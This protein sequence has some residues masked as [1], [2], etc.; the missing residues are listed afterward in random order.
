MSHQEI[1]RVGIVE[2]I[3]SKKLSQIEGSKQLN[4]SSRQMRRLQKRYRKE[5][6]EGLLSKHRGKPSNNQLSEVIKS[7]VSKLIRE[8]YSDFGPTLAH[9]KLV[10]QH[11]IKLS[12]ERV[13]QLMIADELW[14]P[15]QRKTKRVFQLRPRRERFGE[16]IQIDGSP[17][18]W[19]E[20]RSDSCTLI[21]FID[22]A[23]R[24]L[25]SLL[26]S[27]TETTK[28]YMDVLKNHMAHYGRPVSLYSDRHGIFRVNQ[29]EAKS[30]NGHTQF[31]R[32]LDTLDVESIQA[33]TPQAKGRV[34]RAN[35][36]LQDR[37]VKEMRLKGINNLD[38]ANTF[39]PGFISDFNQRFKKPA[40][41]KEDAHR[42][43]L[44]T[45]REI[46]LILSRHSKRKVSNQLEISYEKTI[47]Q[48]QGKRH[49]LKQK[50]ITVCDLFSKE[51]VLLYEGKE[52]AYKPF[53]E[54]RP[55]P[56]TEDE[57]TLNKR[58]DQAIERQSRAAAHK[59]AA[60][61]PWRI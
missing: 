25:T 58:V 9:E 53:S 54:S 60:D 10:E 48:I 32:A 13:R 26:F 55:F 27:P 19:F 33:Q 61:H 23:T 59:P 47:Y 17:H 56:D 5:G 20:G 39:L 4:I 50:Q 21:V 40:K 11:N 38:E 12:V 57:K 7:E 52:I 31:S 8:K 22:D 46:D 35:K 6:V 29:K 34:E 14:V 18:D 43:V 45:P 41:K 16:L 24:R 42:K 2:L 15:K 44:H 49:R 51:I 30:G 3:A 1:D 36:T 28:A 37:L